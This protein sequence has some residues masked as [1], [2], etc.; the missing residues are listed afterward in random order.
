MAATGERFTVHDGHVEFR[1]PLTVNGN[2]TAKAGAAANA[3]CWRGRVT[4]QMCD[5]E[6]CDVPREESF[7]LTL[8]LQGAVVSEL[9]AEPDGKLIRAMNGKQHFQKLATRH[10]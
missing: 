3:E 4:W 7:E 5:D 2:V 9:G 1:L 8:P 10:S 6:V